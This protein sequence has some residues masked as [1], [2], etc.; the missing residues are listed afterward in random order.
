[1]IRNAKIHQAIYLLYVVFSIKKTNGL[2][3]KE[4][5]IL[6]SFTGRKNTYKKTFQTEKKSSRSSLPA[7]LTLTHFLEYQL[8]NPRY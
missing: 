2:F 7:Y 1:M 5:K 6:S 4:V 3:K 8:D